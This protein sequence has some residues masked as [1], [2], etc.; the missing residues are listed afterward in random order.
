[1]I[2]KASQRAG[3]K[4]LAR[5]LL[6]TD[7]NEH[8]EVHDIRGFVSDD[9]VGAF[10]EAFAISKATKC[11]QFLFSVSLNPPPQERVEIS[12]FE[13][14]I[15]RIEEKNGLTGQP[16]AIVFHEKEGRRHAHA[17]WSRIDADTLTAK[18]LPFFK[19]KLR[20]LSRELYLENGW[21][22]PR[23]LMNSREADPRN[24]T[25]KE[26]QQSKRTGR[27]PRDLKDLLQECW[28]IS[29]SAAAFA[30]ALKARGITLA[31]GDRRG[32]VA[33]THDGEVLSVSR[34]TGKKTKEIEARLGK[35]ETYPSIADARTQLA[36]DLSQAYQRQRKEADAL[37][38]HQL[39]PLE[40]KRLEMA[41]AH[42]LERARLDTRQRDRWT[43]ESKERAARIPG[44]MRGLWSRLSGQQAQIQ[45]QNEREAYEALQRDRAQRQAIIDAQIA[46]RQR[47][48]AQIKA[49]RDRHAA[50]LREL[51]AD[52][53]QVQRTL[54]SPSVKREFEAK[55]NPR[56]D[57]RPSTQQLLDRLREGNGSE[58]SPPRDRGK[59][60]DRER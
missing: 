16:R 29:D 41:T 52:Q 14:A 37:K 48:Q 30:Q 42:R 39:A 26:W 28:A 31:R 33:L 24:F 51:R 56:A 60:R 45:K 1:M 7:E 20:D 10:Q 46:E 19:N 49:V 3:G 18:N 27:D 44:G 55:A 2:L 35:P 59:D 38:R 9:L 54:E 8:V 43:L 47:L 17:V 40:Q 23:G 53:K 32:H 21:K 50:L 4:Q 36:K 34:Y 15:Q 12:T 11:K 5:H 13:D 22:M 25:L 57:V 58:P 6:K